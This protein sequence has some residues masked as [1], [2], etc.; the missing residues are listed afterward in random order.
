MIN[1]MKKITIAMFSML[2]I[3]GTL[4]AQTGKKALKIA[5][6]EAAKYT[7]NMSENGAN[8]EKAFE[9]LKVAFQSDEVSSEP[10]YWNQKA[11]LYNKI[12]NSEMNASLLAGDNSPIAHPNAAMM[13]FEAYQKAI[14]LSNNSGKY[15]KAALSGLMETENHLNNTGITAFQVKDYA[16]A[17][18]NFD[19]GVKI[20]ELLKS[21]KKK[22]RID[23]DSIRNEHIFYTGIAAFYGDMRD[24]AIPYLEKNIA[25]SSPNALSYDALFQIFAPL[26][27]EKA[28]G[29]LAQGRAMFP[30]NTSMLF[31]EINHYLKAGK[32]TQLISKL[33][34]AIEVEP[35]NVSVYITMGNVYDQLQVKE[36]EAGNKTKAKEYFDN[37]LDYY[38]QALAKDANNF[39]AI[40]SIGTLYYN[41][42]ANMTTSINKFANDFSKAGMAKYDTAK[43]KMDNTFK[44][45]LPFFEKAEGINP[46]DLNTLIALKEIYARQ[47]KLEKSN[48]IKAR[49]DALRK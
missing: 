15:F 27:E 26:D 14:K 8:L 5:T 6:K 18:K 44:E 33:K 16:S 22:S 43:K 38:N 41:K 36:T 1:K 11:A 13:A 24:E 10:K 25:S 40:Y 31:T 29:Y 20:Y 47:D 37:A 34:K 7:S 49:I 19:A 46:N 32:L 4:S 48:S 17:Y 45:A 12:A 35:D 39:D 21:N 28:L 3:M 30:E 2:L 23:V 9:L 42:A